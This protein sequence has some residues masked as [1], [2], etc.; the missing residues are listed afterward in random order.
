MF[1]VLKHIKLTESQRK[2]I[3][4]TNGLEIFLQPCTQVSTFVLH[5][6]AKMKLT[7][8]FYFQIPSETNQ[9]WKT[10]AIQQKAYPADWDQNKA[11]TNRK[12]PSSIQSN[13]QEENRF[14]P[15]TQERQQNDNTIPQCRSHNKFEWEI[16]FP[17]NCSSAS[18]LPGCHFL[19]ATL[20]TLLDTRRLFSLWPTRSCFVFPVHEEDLWCLKK[21]RDAWRGLAKL[22]TL[23]DI[24]LDVDTKSPA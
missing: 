3:M 23:E 1:V 21:T 16:K 11:T 22:S 20:S 9:P 19:V 13:H 24:V 7:P 5:F 18:R 12:K 14:C 17:F 4:K 2:V 6:I 8:S 10:L 15:S